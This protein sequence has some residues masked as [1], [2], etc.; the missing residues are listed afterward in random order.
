MFPEFCSFSAF[1]SCKVWSPLDPFQNYL[2]CSSILFGIFPDLLF[3]LVWYMTLCKS[4]LVTFFISCLNWFLLIPQYY[5]SCLQTVMWTK[6][7]PRYYV[8]LKTSSC[9]YLI[10]KRWGKV[11]MSMFLWLV[12][13]LLFRCNVNVYFLSYGHCLVAHLQSHQKENSSTFHRDHT[14]HWAHCVIR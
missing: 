14:W 7:I 2:N 4:L 6:I 3:H 12:D 9:A 11:W 8:L 1:C 5:E 13:H 10:A